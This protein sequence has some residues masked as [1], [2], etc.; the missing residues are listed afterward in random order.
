[1]EEITSYGQQIAARFD[2][3]DWVALAVGVLLLVAGR[4]LYWLALAGV[5][6]VAGLTLAGALAESAAPGSPGLEMA[7]TLAGGLLGALLAVWVQK[8]AVL[9]GGLVLGGAAVFW[10][11]PLASWDPEGWIWLA[12]LVGAALGAA[13][14]PALFAFSLVA[15]TSLLG[16][17]L[18]ASHLGLGQP[19]EGWA[20]LGLAA[21]GLLLQARGRRRLRP[22]RARA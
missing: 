4:R 11:A 17:A 1:M 6:F 22:A 7:L 13:L 21:L 8:L 5:G 19:H 2:L 15:F 9:L 3:A 12:A 14:A 20:F 16:A 10:L 18:V